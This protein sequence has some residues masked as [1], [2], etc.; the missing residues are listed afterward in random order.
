LQDRTLKIEYTGGLDLVFDAFRSTGLVS[1]GS[2][3]F[4]PTKENMELLNDKIRKLEFT[5]HVST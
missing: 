2:E 4:I 3:G 1:T 5:E